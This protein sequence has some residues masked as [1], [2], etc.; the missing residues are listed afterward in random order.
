[1]L[2]FLCCSDTHA[3]TPPPLDETDVTAWLHAGDVY[4][5]GHFAKGT[6]T[7]PAIERLSLWMSERKIPVYAVKGNHDCSFDVP[8]FNAAENMTKRCKPIAPHL[9]LYGL[10]WHGSA[11]FDLPTESNMRNVIE[12]AKREWILRSM[13]SD[14]VI[15]LSHYPF[16]SPTLYSFNSNPEGWMFQCI[17]ELMDEIKPLAIIQ[18]HVHEL[19]GR[20]NIYTGPDYE[21]LAVFPGPEGG[22]LSVDPET[23]V[24]KFEFAK[25]Q[26]EVDPIDLL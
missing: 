4:S 13:P 16:W 8:F 25:P 6:K 3:K 26:I 23:S 19:M 10:G 22:T 14:K 24:V 9:F 12:E 18:G 15:I 11:Y 2:K 1:M 17:R 5:H 20:Q 7:S 21:T